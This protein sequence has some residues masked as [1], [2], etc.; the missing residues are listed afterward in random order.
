M[1]DKRNCP[2]CSGSMSAIRLIDKGHA[3]THKTA[4][5]AAIDAKQGWLGRY[6]IE[7]IVNAVMC[8]QCGAIRLYG[9]PKDS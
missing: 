2:E 8:Q 3:E 6:P 7:G 1:N 9:E 5:Y 4:E